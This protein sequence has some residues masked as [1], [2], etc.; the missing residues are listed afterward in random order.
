MS[1][2]ETLLEGHSWYRRRADAIL[3]LLLTDCVGRPSRKCFRIQRTV[4]LCYI[5]CSANSL[6]SRYIAR[7]TKIRFNDI[8]HLAPALTAK[9][10]VSDR[11]VQKTVSSRFQQVPGTVHFVVY[12]PDG[13]TLQS[14][15]RQRRHAATHYV[16]VIAS[17]RCNH[18]DNGD[19]DNDDD[20]DNHTDIPIAS[21]L[22]LNIQAQTSSSNEVIKIVIYL[23]ISNTISSLLG[24]RT[25]YT[26]A[27]SPFVRWITRRNYM[28]E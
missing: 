5:C 24:V 21:M 3:H 13:A 2:K 16:S 20:N 25:T 11:N 19:D 12:R 27:S 28:I 17:S 22:S 23:I 10:V 15:R 9:V 4:R 14:W 7:R 6:P 18:Y 26:M 1:R 8:Q